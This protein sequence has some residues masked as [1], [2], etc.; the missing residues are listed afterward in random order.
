MTLVQGFDEMSSVSRLVLLL[1]I[2]QGI[3]CYNICYLAQTIL[4]VA[5][6]V[7]QVLL[8]ISFNWDV[9][10]AGVVLLNAMERYCGIVLTFED[11][12]L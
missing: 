10:I 5:V 6:I 7:L 9:C 12:T 4:A 1:A 8:L 2:M 3:Q 11:N